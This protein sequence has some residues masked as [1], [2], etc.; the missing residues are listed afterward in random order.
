M[1]R[2]GARGSEGDA[3]RANHREYEDEKCGQGPGTK[4]HSRCSLGYGLFGIVEQE[5]RRHW[6]DIR[7]RALA[8]VYPWPPDDLNS[9]RRNVE[10][11]S[12]K[13]HS[14]HHDRKLARHSD[15]RL[16]TSLPIFELKPPGS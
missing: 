12:G 13:P 7:S 10:V 11:L 1:N 8:V 4:S 5:A 16:P 9:C 3:N 15:Q 2:M 6:H 14:V